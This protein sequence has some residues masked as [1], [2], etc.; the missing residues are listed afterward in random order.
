[1]NK[2]Y[3]HY[4]NQALYA[5]NLSRFQFIQAGLRLCPQ[6]GYRKLSVRLLAAGAGLSTG[7]FHHS[8][9]DKNAFLM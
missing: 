4:K 8:F 2:I 6:Y 1:M 9:V 5:A 3:V 7:V